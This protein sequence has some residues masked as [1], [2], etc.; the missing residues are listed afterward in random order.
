[1]TIDAAHRTATDSIVSPHADPDMPTRMSGSARPMHF[2]PQWRTVSPMPAVV[3]LTG[4]AVMVGMLS[5]LSLIR[6]W[7][8][9]G[10]LTA[11]DGR[12]FLAI[13]ADGYQ[14]SP[15]EPGGSSP[16]FLPGY[17][18]LVAALHTVTGLPL[19]AAAI[20]LS[21]FSGIAFAYAIP[22]LVRHIPGADESA[23]IVAIALVAIAPESI[24]FVMAYSEALFCALASWSL[25]AAL[26]HRWYLAAL[27]ALPAG[28]VRISG[29][30]LAAAFGAAAIAALIR[31]TRT[32]N[33][34]QA[35]RR[36]VLRPAAAAVIA[37]AG[38]AGWIIGSGIR[39]GSP[40]AWF[41][42]QQS[43]WDSRWDYGATTAKYIYRMAT[44]APNIWE[45]ATA[46]ILIIA[47]VLLAHT[48]R[49]RPPLLLVAYSAA[50]LAE[51]IGSSGIMNARIRLL[52]PAF[53]ILLPLA[54]GLTR[55]RKQ[56]LLPTLIATALASSW[57]TAYSL[58]IWK[59]AI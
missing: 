6:G 25:V 8:L 38:T 16:A 20:T 22:H 37:A 54:A 49:S 47:C 43:G 23:G 7:S 39:M 29:L 28:L 14:W 27:L 50:A 51:V 55:L 21:F 4:Q 48:I 33:T 19:P 13:A 56:N 40:T 12:H 32:G 36:A 52:I 45:V 31:A 2:P 41:T 53:T 3:F 30:A 58:T 1:M 5:W 35:A 26:R 11:W 17:P 18:T 15:G 46:G 9:I 57:L 24:V 34:P 10:R 59:Y 42:A 44:T